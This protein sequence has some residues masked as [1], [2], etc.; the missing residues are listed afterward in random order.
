M[1]A[2]LL[3]ALL[4]QQLP[5]HVDKVDEKIV[6]ER[7][8][9]DARVVVGNGQPVTGLTPA[10]FTVRIDGK[11]ARV[12][13]ADWIPETAAARELA[14]VDKPPVEVN[15]TLDI[16]PP[17]GRLFILF[18]QTDLAREGVR[19]GGQMQMN[20]QVDTLLGM[21][22]PDDRVAV[23]SFDSHL[24]FR[25]DFTDDRARL[26]GAMQ[27]AVLM[28]EPNTPPI[29]P[30]PS[31]AA[32]LTREAMLRVGK[33]EDALILIANALRPIPGPKSLLFIGFGLGRFGR[34]GAR[35]E[36]NYPIARTALEAARVS[37]FTLDFTQASHHSLETNL[38]QV[39]EDTGG[40]YAKTNMFP[41]VAIE[42]LHNTLAGH[43][44]LEVRK[45]DDLRRGTHTIE[46][47]VDRRNAEVYARTTYIDR[48]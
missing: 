40:F 8:L 48:D 5:S 43:Y 22:E 45:P 2:A 26:S 31:L 25:L 41:K 33:P 46:V 34:G 13:S 17:R 18:Y 23:F 37:V 19:L 27:E 12:M 3:L 32:R 30:S 21:L 11:P 28:N 4:A 1:L 44:E 14:D 35:Q 7:I 20:Q 29:V 47:S 42:R 36:L 39:A 24:K 9:V 10:N 6:V 16:Q 38:G 15:H